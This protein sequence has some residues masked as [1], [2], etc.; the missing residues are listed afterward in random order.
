MWRYVPRRD[1]SKT[2]D[3]WT[4]PYRI[5]HLLGAYTVRLDSG[6]VVNIS[7]LK[8]KAERWQKNDFQFFIMD[9]FMNACCEH[10]NINFEA[11]TDY[12]RMEN[13]GLDADWSGEKVVFSLVDYEWTDV[14]L[15]AVY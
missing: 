12:S 2:D 6:A 10:W 9:K 8:I 13:N 11:F 3:V 15:K 4:G 14:L 7:D 5:T 1:R